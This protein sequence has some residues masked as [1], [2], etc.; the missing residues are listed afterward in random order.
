M[1]VGFLAGA[2]AAG[3][4]CVL[5]ALL[6]MGCGRDDA[7]VDTAA[8]PAA[9]MP[10]S[11]VLAG[12][13]RAVPLHDAS[14]VLAREAIEAEVQ[15]SRPAGRLARSRASPN[16]RSWRRH[17]H[18]LP[19]VSTILLGAYWGP[20]EESRA[21]AIE[22]LVR[23]LSHAATVDAAFAHWYRQGHSPKPEREIPVAVGPI[24]KFVTH[25]GD[26]PADAPQELGHHFSAWN[27]GTADL[28][29][30]I[31]AFSRRVGNSVVL[32]S[33]PLAS[34]DAWRRLAE[35][36]ITIFQPDRLVVTRQVRENGKTRPAGDLYTY[37]RRGELVRG[38]GGE[39]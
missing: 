15:P 2:K 3:A 38:G 26:G 16:V 1:R 4:P 27:G 9:D 23:F 7:P 29:V 12:P 10:D 13:V 33:D 6:A 11:I 25:K 22:R 36:A 19:P 32:D 39:T 24:G 35:A 31:G 34:E 30:C 18:P 20:R 8:S 28:N 37:D 21:A 5:V 14:L 17:G